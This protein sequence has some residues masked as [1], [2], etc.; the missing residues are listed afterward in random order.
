VQ[1][2][3]KRVKVVE[4]LRSAIPEGK[5]QRIVL[6]VDDPLDLAEYNLSKDSQIVV[7]SIDRMNVVAMKS[8]KEG[9]AN[10]KSLTDIL[11]GMAAGNSGK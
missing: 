3:E 7:A 2:D 1:D 8:F 9:E 5:L 6:G 4:G 10:Q 11:L